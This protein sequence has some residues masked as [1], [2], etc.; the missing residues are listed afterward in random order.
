[1]SQRQQAQP[2]AEDIHTITVAQRGLSQEQ[3][4]RTRKYLLSMGIRTACVLA[5]IVVPGWP[6]WVFIVGAVI[7]P[8]FAV[9]IANA[10][11]R[12]DAPGDVGVV[13]QSRPALPSA[14]GPVLEGTIVDASPR[15]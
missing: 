4:S 14:S 7:L 1:M 2:A 13:S 3:A 9:V 15:P 11:R 10:G 5:A 6:K 12:R 8:Y